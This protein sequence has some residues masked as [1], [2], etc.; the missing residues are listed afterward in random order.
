MEF[1]TFSFAFGILCNKKH[2]FLISHPPPPFAHWPSAV[3]IQLNNSAH[4]LPP[5]STVQTNTHTWRVPSRMIY[6]LRLLHVGSVFSF[7]QLTCIYILFSIQLTFLS[8][9]F[10]TPTSKYGINPELDSYSGPFTCSDL[11]N[12]DLETSWAQDFTTY[13]KIHQYITH[14]AQSLSVSF[15]YLISHPIVSDL[16]TVA[17]AC[18]LLNCDST[19][20]LK[21]LWGLSFLWTFYYHSPH[22]QKLFCLYMIDPGCFI[23]AH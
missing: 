15:S 9:R 6:G 18:F 23:E 8:T 3:K 17:A 10:W 14:F 22:R 16:K 5:F 4:F 19:L 13:F 7:R 1:L 2:Q 11:I 20:V 21:Y 12:S